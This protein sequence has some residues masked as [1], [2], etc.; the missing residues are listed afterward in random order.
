MWGVA[1]AAG[2]IVNDDVG[3]FLALGGILVGGTVDSGMGCLHGAFVT[4]IMATVNRTM[5]HS[6]MERVGS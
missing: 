1:G 3:S 4:L 2:R 6:G 5:T